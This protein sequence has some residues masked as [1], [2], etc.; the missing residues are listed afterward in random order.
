MQR[1]ELY[2][3]LDHIKISHGGCTECDAFLNDFAK[4]N[5]KCSSCDNI[6]YKFEKDYL[7]SHK[8]IDLCRGYLCKEHW[9]DCMPESTPWS[10]IRQCD[11]CQNKNL[12]KSCKN[13]DRF[14]N[15]LCQRC[16][17]NSV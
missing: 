13:M 3:L 6:L 17:N 15:F 5:V 11:A 8:L 14:G 7:E 1:N 10:Y 2:E 16:H 4:S 12:C 9:C